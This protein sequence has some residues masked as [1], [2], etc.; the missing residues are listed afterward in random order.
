[1]SA[2]PAPVKRKKTVGMLLY[3]DLAH[4]SRVRREATTLAGAGYRIVLVCLAGTQGT[5]DLPPGVEVLVRRPGVT[6]AFPGPSNPYSGRAGSRLSRRVRQARWLV[7]YVRNVRSWGRLAVDACG[8]VDVWH[9]NDLP[10]LVAIAPGLS[11]GA[12]VIYDSHELFLEAVEGTR[13]SAAGH[14]RPLV[15]ARVWVAATA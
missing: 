2:R 4:D 7:D 6:A 5:P 10:G 3:G 14:E 8:L 15:P 9:A 11:K 12:P 1:M 13:R